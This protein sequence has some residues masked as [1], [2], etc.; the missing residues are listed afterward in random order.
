MGVRWRKAGMTRGLTGRSTRAAQVAPQ[1]TL[2]F[3]DSA[4]WPTIN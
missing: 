4:H 3:L 2:N 1:Q